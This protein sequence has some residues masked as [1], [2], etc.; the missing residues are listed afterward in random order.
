MKFVA[1]GFK[2]AAY[3]LFERC[4]SLAQEMLKFALEDAYVFVV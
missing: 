3:V 4:L 1:Y 2:K